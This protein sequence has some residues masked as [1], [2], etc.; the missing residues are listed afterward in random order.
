MADPTPPR[1]PKTVPLGEPLNLSDEEIARITSPE[2]LSSPEV[3]AETRAWWK[4]NARP[5]DANL[6]DPKDADEDAAP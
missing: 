1:P 3:I 4:R 2:Y 6:L 5:E